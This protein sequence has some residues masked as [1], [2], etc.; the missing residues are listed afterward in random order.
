MVSTIKSEQLKAEYLSI[1]ISTAYRT[2]YKCCDKKNHKYKLQC[3]LS[4]SLC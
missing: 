1:E 2:S 3:N 4:K